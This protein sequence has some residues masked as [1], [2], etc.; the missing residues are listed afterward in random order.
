MGKRVVTERERAY[1]TLEYIV[2]W[3]SKSPGV[4]VSLNVAKMYQIEK[5]AARKKK[6]DLE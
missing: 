3:Y 4:K 5:A 2:I 6:P 1:P